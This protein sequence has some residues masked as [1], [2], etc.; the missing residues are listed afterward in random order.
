MKKKTLTVGIIGFGNI[1]KKRYLAL[2][3]IKKYKVKIIF[4]VDKKKPNINLKKIKYYSNWIKIKKK[5][6]DLIII[7]TPTKESA[8]ISDQ[9]SGKFNLLV[10]KPLSTKINKIKKIISNSNLFKK[11]IKVGYN[12]RFDDGLIK[13]KENYL[14]SKI[15]KTYY[16]KITYANGAAKTNTNKI[17]SLLDMGSHS[18][19]IIEWLLNNSKLKLISNV[20]QK[21]EFLNK[22]K[23]DNGFAI[24]KSKK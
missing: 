9:L 5:N 23:I 7:S 17:G 2:L 4:I 12:L 1:G 13:A 16:I 6:V 10:E 21:N 22:S 14:N 18:I 24:F 15:G 11:I 3:R 20:F 8:E 19:N